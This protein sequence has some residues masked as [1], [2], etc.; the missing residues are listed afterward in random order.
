MRLRLISILV[1]VFT[2]TSAHAVSPLPTAPVDAAHPGSQ[3]YTY[4]VVEHQIQCH[5]RNVAVFLPHSSQ[6]YPAQGQAPFPV[7]VYGHGQ[8]MSLEVY[9]A[10]FEHLAKKGVAVIFPTYDNGFFDQDWTRMGRDYV[11][12]TACALE[13]YQTELAADK[14][15][16]SGHSK[17]AYVA[18][19][20]AG[21]AVQESL[22]P[23]ARSVVLFEAAGFDSSAIAA[24]EPTTALTVVFSDRDKT[25]ERNLSNSIYA[26]AKSTCKQ[27]IYLKSYGE[28]TSAPLLADHFWPLTKP[29]L[30]GGGKVGPFHYFGEWKWLVAAAQ[31]LNEGAGC[32]N[33]YL[34]G[35]LASDKGVEGLRDDITRNF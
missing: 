3:I 10:T 1:S 35:D 6:A 27:F 34:Y 11:Q 2:L 17:G 31:D 20:A 21:I 25:V 26:G 13:T 28:P 16:F 14:V 29:S 7:V 33:P 30:F 24:I 15:V 23:H 8:S 32:T 22:T 12:L 9:Q 19:V 4:G 18:S 5:G